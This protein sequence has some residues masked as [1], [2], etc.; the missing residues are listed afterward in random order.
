VVGEIKVRIVT[1]QLSGRLLSVRQ[2]G[3]TRPSHSAQS[4][5]VGEIKFQGSLQAGRLL[6]VG[7]RFTPS[8]SSSGFTAKRRC[9]ITWFV[10]RGWIV[11][12]IPFDGVVVFLFTA[13]YHSIA[14]IVQGLQVV[15]RLAAYI[16]CS[17]SG[18]NT[19]VRRHPALLCK[20]GINRTTVV[21]MFRGTRSSLYHFSN[22]P[23]L[24]L[25]RCTTLNRTLCVFMLDD[26]LLLRKSSALIQ[27]TQ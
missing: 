20:R 14:M 16:T 6:R 25:T 18:K 21:Q 8:R 7:A 27:R 9:N 23:E 1:S 22:S 11:H 13:R 24:S 3:R 19:Y 17:V 10:E 4:A 2:R 5:P 15:E 12:V 26:G